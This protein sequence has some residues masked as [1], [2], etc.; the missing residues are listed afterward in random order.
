MPPEN[1][2]A[3][4][5]GA[6]KRQDRTSFETLLSRMHI[7]CFVR[8]SLKSLS[9]ESSPLKTGVEYIART[10]TNLFGRNLTFLIQQWIYSFSDKKTHVYYCYSWEA[11]TMPLSG[12]LADSS[13]FEPALR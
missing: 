12:F 13:F 10:I 11:I 2:G 5:S 1:S 3:P 7:N 9:F 6:H 8:L 4:R